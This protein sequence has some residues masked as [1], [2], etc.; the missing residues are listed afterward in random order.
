MPPHTSPPSPSWLNALALVLALHL[1]TTAGTWWITDHGETLASAHQFLWAGRLD[2]RDLGPGWET[3]DRI[4]AARRSTASR[5]PPLTSLSLVPFL[6][7]D[8]AL[9]WRTPEALRFVHLQGHFFVGL[10]LLL[11]GRFIA[12]TSGRASTAALAV[13]LLGLNWP[14]W[15]IARRLGPEP[16]L[17][18]LLT[19]FVTGGKRSRLVSMLLLPWVH[20]SG[21]L[22]ALGALCWLAMEERGTQDASF[23]LAALGFVAG[24]LSVAFLWNLPVHGHVLLGGYSSFQNDPFFSLR[25]PI[26]GA[27]GMV[28]PMI[29]WNVSLAGLTIRGGTRA[30]TQTIALFLPV[31]VF[32]GLFSSPE[33]ERRLAPLIL[34]WGILVMAR[35]FPPS[36]PVSMGLCATALASGVLGLSRDF[37]AMVGTPI[38]VFSGPHLLLLRLAFVEGHPKVAGGW[39]LL[40]L[41]LAFVA[42][43]RA[44][45]L[46]TASAAAVGPNRV[47]GPESPS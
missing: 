38:G 16:I 28:L 27:L 43:S 15:M 37:V 20:A 8:H 42:G 32:F 31:I 3:W 44:L 11:A 5:F 40:L 7:V 45:G 6:L 12:R 39:L 46:I 30:L 25:N 34:P 2:L 41:T 36:P 35:M 10:S 4:T 19:A 23:R 9:G 33:P 21:P 18:A 17:L 47:A 1:L 22:L 14:V 26:V 24:S 13:M 29:A